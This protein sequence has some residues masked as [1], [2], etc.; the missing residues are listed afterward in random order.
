M[1]FSISLTQQSS[2]TEDSPHVVICAG[3]PS[4]A[5]EATMGDPPTVQTDVLAYCLLLYDAHD[6]LRCGRNAHEVVAAADRLRAVNPDHTLVTL[7]MEKAQTLGAGADPTAER[8]L[9]APIPAREPHQSERP[10]VGAQ[11]SRGGGGA[12]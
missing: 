12:P 3:Q 2:L 5:E 8:V 1:I 4:P 7:L 9:T 10:G 6:M 11:R